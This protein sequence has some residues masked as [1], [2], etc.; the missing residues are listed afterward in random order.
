[1]IKLV[2]LGAA[3][4]PIIGILV[5]LLI[6]IGILLEYIKDNPI[7]DWLE[8]CPW[9]NLSEQRYPNMEIEQAQFQ[10]AIKG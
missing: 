1:M 10:Q 5:V 3:A 7:Q 2:A 9:G 8:R 6:G 4:I